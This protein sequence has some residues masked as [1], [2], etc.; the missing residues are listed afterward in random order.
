M[1]CLDLSVI[2]AI[3]ACIAVSTSA[4]CSSLKLS[5]HFCSP[6]VNALPCALFVETTLFKLL[7]SA[8]FFTATASCSINSSRSTKSA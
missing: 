4:N 7:K 5:N 6:F 1:N 8:N 3:L 2:F